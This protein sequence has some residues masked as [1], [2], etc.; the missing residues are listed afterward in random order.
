MTVC[1]PLVVR[2]LFSHERYSKELGKVMA[3][4]GLGNL[5]IPLLAGIIYDGT[6][7]Y[8]AFWIGG[9]VVLLIAMTLFVQGFRWTKR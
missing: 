1:P 8:N 9:S 5:G 2:E 6:G 7:S 3:S 4:I